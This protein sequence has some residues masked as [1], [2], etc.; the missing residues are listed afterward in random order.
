MSLWKEIL[1][2]SANGDTRAARAKLALDLPLAMRE[3]VPSSRGS[4]EYRGVLPQAVR[5][6]GAKLSEQER[7][8]V[9]SCEWDFVD[10]LVD[11]VVIGVEKPLLLIELCLGHPDFTVEGLVSN[12]AWEGGLKR[13]VAWKR[14]WIANHLRSL[15]EAGIPLPDGIVA[16]LG[17][18]GDACFEYNE[19][20][21]AVAPE[22]LWRS[23][24]DF[25]RQHGYG[26]QFL[27]VSEETDDTRAADEGFDYGAI[28]ISEIVI[29]Q[30][31]EEDRELEVDLQILGKSL[32][33]DL[34]AL[35]D[36]LQ[37]E[38]PQDGYRP[39]AWHHVF[40]NLVSEYVRLRLD[41][42]LREPFREKDQ[43]LAD[44]IKEHYSEVRSAS[45]P[46]VLRRRN[47]LTKACD[48]LIKSKFRERFMATNEQS[49]EQIT[50]VY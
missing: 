38:K 8:L 27:C 3:F 32:T 5:R 44:Y 12:F 6:F 9:K 21:F 31:S 50:H 13:D 19:I 42:T 33:L 18:E 41:L 49:S 48:D 2:L 11:D 43:E 46:V 29:Q 30:R 7:A 24:N 14:L 17:D 34:D 28:T 37:A 4:R 39:I 1:L 47:N 22:R 10:Y 26:Q 15:I 23:W 16:A 40:W 35:L 45:R 36:E 25:K 20:A